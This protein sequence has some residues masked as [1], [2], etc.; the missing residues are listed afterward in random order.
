MF[1]SI[2]LLLIAII[3]TFDSSSI[4]VNAAIDTTPD[5]IEFKNPL[6]HGYGDD[7]DWVKWD[8]AIETAM[9]V[10]KPIFM[11]IHKSWCGACK[12]LK[13]TFRQSSAQ[14]AFTALSA[15]FVMVNTE[16]DD[17]PWEEEY[18]PDGKYIPRLLFLDQNGELLADFKNTK[19][20]YKTYMYYY[21]NPADILI[22]MRA[23]L[24]HLGIDAPETKKGDKLKP[25]TT[26]DENK[27]AKLTPPDADDESKKET[28]KEEEPKKKVETKKKL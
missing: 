1:R 25:P 27:K 7:I 18:K 6:S 19:A 2:C 20:E 23:V 10:Q 13:K 9:A 26:T 21:S 11:L 5:D 4:F 8:D 28:V 16:D 12:S 15:Y 24:K 14:R 22:S 3:L 17:E